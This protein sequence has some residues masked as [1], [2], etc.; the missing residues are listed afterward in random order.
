MATGGSL[1][2]ALRVTLGLDSSQFEAGTKRARS[3][4]SRDARAIQSE[5]SKI[6]QGFDNLKNAAITTALVA[7][8]KRALEYASSLG[9]V[10]QQAGVTTKELQEYRYAASQVGISNEEM[11]KS[12]TKLT[13]SI[14]EAKA[15]SKEQA[16]VFR[17][18]GVAIQDANGRVYTAG[19]VIPKLADA[20]SKIKDPATRARYEVDLFGK[21]GQKLDTLLS[22]GSKAVDE[23]RDAA[24]KLGI[25]LSDRQI[26][27]A[28]ETADKLAAL[29]Q[30][31]EA[32][33]AGVVADNANAILSLAGAF[34]ALADMAARVSKEVPGALAIAGGAAAGGL[35][36][37][38]KGAA[39]GGLIGFGGLLLDRA[40][41][42]PLGLRNETPKNLV[43][44]QRK[45]TAQIKTS[46]RSGNAGT[47]EFA[48]LV[49]M[50]NMIDAEI[51]RRM[52]GLRASQVKPVVAGEVGDGA[53][54][55]VTGGGE[56][57]RGRGRGEKDRTQEYLERFNREMAG[58]ADDQL[59][60]MAEQTVNLDERAQIEAKRILAERQAYEYDVDSR[61]KQGELTKEQGES[62]KLAKAANAAQE[63]AIMFNRIQAEK[64]GQTAELRNAT[65]DL[66][67]EDLQNQLEEARTADERRRISLKL[68]DLQYEKER[69]EIAQVEALYELGQ[70][71]DA[72][73]DAARNRL[74]KLVDLQAGQA[75]QVRRDTMG[76]MESYLDSLPRTADELKERFA[77]IKVD[78]LNNG[79]DLAS[80]NVLK[81]KGFAGDLFNQLIA[82]VIRLN[83][84]SAIAGGGGILG[85]L[86]KLLG[87]AG[88]MGSGGGMNMSG[89]DGAISGFAPG[90]GA[91]GAS[92][93][94]A[95]IL[96]SGPIRI[97]GMAG[98]GSLRVGGV[99]GVDRNILSVNGIPRAR[100]SANENI[101]VGYGGNA[102][103]ARIEIVEH[104]GFAARVVGISGNVAV[105][106]TR[107]SNTASYRRGRQRLG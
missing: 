63:Q 60:L 83:L 54:P 76:P 46:S 90:D 41:N 91:N 73:L 51:G 10:A 72:E 97:P 71:T 88:G 78:A 5:L 92:A 31:L 89:W 106:T 16:T 57:G 11:D 52:A 61:I 47:A 81:L 26:Q 35:L 56:R 93:A 77:S 45:L 79:L 87:L 102:A 15:G 25:V 4:A 13:R 40:K 33:I 38:P 105:E 44:R 21:T 82:D 24:Q 9:E 29:K 86:G 62:L 3:I 49:Q 58:L 7:A 39:A 69:A 80:R 28:D 2:G 48:E 12:L 1:I 67:R 36:G 96:Q 59:Q 101:K 95:Q 22:G 50:S 37:G 103:A 66:Q 68:L 32:R 107:A 99:P 70:A 34:S 98:G 84:Q 104:P 75:R 18:L 64:L 20:L 43:A 19:E 74:A 14:G 42:D 53:L 17:D 30:V 55:T 100:V 8:G 94:L 65:Y 23:L 27:N 6:R 85:S